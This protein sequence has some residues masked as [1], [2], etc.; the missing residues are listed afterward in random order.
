M[1][2]LFFEEERKGT[3]KITQVAKIKGNQD[4]AIF[5]SELFRFNSEGI[6][7]V[8]D[9]SDI[10]KGEIVELEAVSSFKLDAAEKIVPHSN[11]VCFGCEY[12]YKEDQ[13]PLLYSN[14][15]NNYNDAC[16]GGIH[17]SWSIGI[18]YSQN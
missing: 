8:Y 13:Y 4:G 16:C 6:C 14:V 11:S 10:K 18:V 12:Y 17:N 7:N 9:L 5:G 2:T 15:Y 1:N 3:V